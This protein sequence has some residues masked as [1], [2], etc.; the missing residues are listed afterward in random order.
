[1]H[2]RSFFAR[3]TNVGRRAM[4]QRDQAIGRRHEA[5]GNRQ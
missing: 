5:I 4:L 3:I 2:V 1:M